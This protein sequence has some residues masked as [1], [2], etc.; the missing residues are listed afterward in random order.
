MS[1]R[2]IWR[3]PDVSVSGTPIPLSVT[4]QPNP[5]PIDA[6]RWDSSDFVPPGTCPRFPY[7]GKLKV[8]D[9]VASTWCATAWGEDLS[10]SGL[11]FFSTVDLPLRAYV[12]VELELNG[13]TVQ[14][15]ACIMRRSG[16]RYGAEF[17]HIPEATRLLLEEWHS[18]ATRE[19]TR[20]D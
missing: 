16:T 8:M 11:G 6:A 15:Q 12:I 4:L 19:S 14:L 20:R 13:T 17:L 7:N 18:R 1:D 10:C 5:D 2:S 9:A 3:R